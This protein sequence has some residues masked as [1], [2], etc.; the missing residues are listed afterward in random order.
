MNAVLRRRIG[1]LLLAALLFSLLPCTALAEGGSEVLLPEAELEWDVPEI[2]ADA[3]GAEEYVEISEENFPDP[4]FRDYLLENC[5]YTDGDEVRYFTAGQLDEVRVIALGASGAADLT[6]IEHFIQLEELNVSGCTEL[7]ELNIGRNAVLTVLDCAD[8]GLV[9]LDISE[10]AFLTELVKNTVPAEENEILTYEAS[11]LLLRC[12]RE[13]ELITSR[14]VTVFF[15]KNA[16]DAEGGMEPQTGGRREA[17]PLSENAFVRENWLFD[18]WNTQADGGGDSYT[19]LLPEEKAVGELT[20]YAQWV[21]EQITLTLNAN[22]GGDLPDT[23]ERQ[24]EKGAACT[25]EANPFTRDPLVFTGWS[26]QADGDGERW[27]DGGTVPAELTAEDLTLYARWADPAMAT[28][29]AQ[30]TAG[31]ALHVALLL[32]LPDALPPARCRLTAAF[33][34]KTTVD[35]ELSGADRGGAAYVFPGAAEAGLAQMEELISVT[36]FFDGKKIASREFS[37]FDY[38]KTLPAYA[39]A[40]LPAKEAGYAGEIDGVGDFHARLDGASAVLYFR[41]ESADGLTFVCDGHTLSAPEREDAG[42]W[43]VTAGDLTPADLPADL[44]ITAATETQQAQIRFSPFC[45]AAGHWEETD[46]PLI[47]LCR[48]LAAAQS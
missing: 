10:N 31:D 40:P 23:V 9:S 4:V 34:G 41:A 1:C 36:L 29:S 38:L 12:G 39:E 28:L 42:L 44:L 17:L 33:D 37:V 43:S 8:T 22:E 46:D 20:L 18:H 27:G 14:N 26:T 2:P 15:D 35:R 6:G 3:D 11:G 21:R 16:D 13:L 30:I 25:L 32:T 24:I 45:W 19:D 47:A 48:A 5:A 7:T